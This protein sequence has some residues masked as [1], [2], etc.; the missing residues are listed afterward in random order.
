MEEAARAVAWHRGEKSW[1][2]PLIADGRLYV[3][4]LDALWCY[5]LRG[6]KAER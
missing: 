3:R 2:Y 4:D 1:A 5:D 6:K